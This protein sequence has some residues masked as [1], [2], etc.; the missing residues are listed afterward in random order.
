MNPTNDHGSVD[1]ELD[2]KAI[3]QISVGIAVVVVISFLVAG[4]LLPVFEEHNASL[5][6]PPSPLAEANQPWVPPG[7][8]LQHFPPTTDLRSLEAGQEERLHS[9]GWVD[10]EAGIVHIPVERAMEVIAGRGLP[11]RGDLDAVSVEIF[12]GAAPQEAP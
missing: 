4:W 8:G 12:G 11:S 5:N 2:F 10:Q 7:P 9:Y 1:R 6:P 3:V